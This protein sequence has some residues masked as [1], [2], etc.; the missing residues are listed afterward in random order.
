MVG[1]LGG[2]AVSAGAESSEPNS[3]VGKVKDPG[4]RRAEAEIAP[5]SDEGTLALQRMKLAPGLEAKLWAAEPMLANPV[6]FNFDERGR[7]FVAETYRYRTS[8]LDIR[9]YMWML[10]D[11]LTHRNQA[12]WTATLE[13]R[14]G[15]AGMR[16]LSIESERVRLLEDTN[17]GGRADRSTVFAEGFNGPLDGIASGVL[18]RR[19][20][21]WMTSIPSLWLLEGE[22]PAGAATKRT[23]LSRGY[24]VRFNYTGHDMHGL[25]FGPDGKIYYSVGDRG[26][27]VTTPEG[28]LLSAPDTGSVFRCNP[29]G[30]QLELF[31]T[32]LRNPQ[33]LLFTENGDLLTGDNDC[34]K[35][36]EERLVHIVEGGDS[37]WRIGYQFA[38]L[39]KDSPWLA[40][41]LWQ[42]RHEGQAAYLIPP[43]CNMEDGP[44]GIAYYP[45]TGLNE[46]YRGAIFVTHF[47]G[48]IARSG[49]YTYNLRP[50]GATYAIEDSK[51]FLTSALP[52]DVKFGPDGRLYTSDWADGW[53]KSK[54]GRIYAISD[55]LRVNDPLVRETKQLIGS[56]WPKKS[57]D[58]LGAL[59]G[60]ADWRVRLEAQFT[61]AERGEAA[62]PA[63]IRA[64]Y[65]DRPPLARRHA[66]WGLGQI[67]GKSR[68]ALATI[69]T[70]IRHSDPEVRAQGIKLLGDLRVTETTDALITALKDDNLRVKFFAAQSLGKLG[71]AAATPALLEALRANNDKDLYLRHACVMGLVG[72][73]N[74]E[75]LVAAVADR[76]R[77]VRLGVLLALRRLSRPEIAKFLND[78]DPIL[79]REAAL[80]I[81]DAPI[82]DALPALAALIDRPLNDEAVIYRALN[83]HFRLGQPDNARALAAYAARPEAPAKMRGEALAQ[84]SFWPQPPQRDRLVGVYRPFATPTR[85]RSVA[86]KALEPKLSGLLAAGTPAGVQTATL[87]ALQDLA[88]AGAAD[89]LF[90]VVRDAQQSGESRAA[91]LVAL[92]RIKDPRLAEA[93]RLAGESTASTLRLAALPIASRLSPDS[94]A[95]VLANL[96]ARGNIEEKKMAYGALGNSKHPSADPL[97]A[98]QLREL[99]AGRIPPAVQLELLTAAGR[100]RDPAIKE[101]LAARE[102]KLAASPDPLDTYRVAVAGGNPKRGQQIFETQPTLACIRCHRAG[103]DGGEAGPNLAGIGVKATREHLLESIVK[104]N[105]KIAPGFDTLV[106]TL[107]SGGTVAGMVASETNETITLR[108]PDNQLVAVAK[109]TVARRDGAPSGMPEV[110]GGLLTKSELRDVVEYLATLTQEQPR[111]ETNKPRAL[112]TLAAA[113][114]E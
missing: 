31:A 6:A 105:A 61:L 97:L 77:A 43:I 82:N 36:D 5:A 17:G 11:E 91:A 75:A 44:S 21:V 26:A 15:E 19:G 83:A 10:E 56:D 2:V 74:S 73:G 110:Y 112:R 55:P 22:T 40:D 41:N 33:S 84:L 96:V 109:S 29:D 81:N 69:K 107:K 99:A 87:K 23:E 72:S 48:S 42:P 28:V 100:R 66:V 49:I 52:T 9:D 103:A 89:T 34:D 104:P 68:E 35:G 57:F 93:V 13:R 94:A 30:S 111:S 1:L 38:A 95:P 16:E 37:G 51:P 46:T 70:F 88:V 24:G 67:A 12:D 108:T 114:T 27:A 45:G 8:V 58:E 14:L 18:A 98:E 32:G 65:L 80:A 92:D 63:L 47:K 59:L 54:R 71:Q 39:E 102:A 85:D 64:A 7:M 106:L 4:S 20:K 101:L 50:K 3:R 113:R 86:V 62:A 25:A 53:P 76:S 79:V 90:A 60:H 78:A